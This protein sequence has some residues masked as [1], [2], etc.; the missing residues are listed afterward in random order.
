MEKY[1]KL[2]ILVAS[3]FF[4]K[5]AFGQNKKVQEW[6]GLKVDSSCNLRWSISLDGRFVEINDRTIMADEIK[7]SPSMIGGWNK[8]FYSLSGDIP[9]Y[10][11][12]GNSLLDATF[13]V[14]RNQTKNG[15]PIILSIVNTDEVNM[16]R[17]T[18]RRFEFKF[19]SEKEVDD[20]IAK[21]DSAYIAERKMVEGISNKISETDKNDFEKIKMAYDWVLRTFS[22][23]GDRMGRYSDDKYIV[24]GLDVF[25]E[26]IYKVPFMNNGTGGDYAHSMIL[27]ELFD[28][29]GIE[30]VV[31][32]YAV[33]GS[34]DYWNMAKL[35]GKW[36][37]LDA[38]R[39]VKESRHYK[40]FLV[41]E[42]VMWFG[43]VCEETL[44][45]IRSQMGILGGEY[46]VNIPESP[47]SY[48]L[49]GVTKQMKDEQD[50]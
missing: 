19:A 22:L 2:A 44:A 49:S 27:K 21:I 26:G 45:S 47:T 10:L 7:I 13:R 50:K 4:V 40:C 25:K 12:E 38:T 20:F 30:S 18:I 9:T 36:Y 43:E 14:R 42:K 28:N 8:I 6:E 15:E 1:L 3:L 41:S 39:E 29:I 37:N 34:I 11:L 46:G 48:N 23:G 24:G 33:D 5:D 16:T 31:V 17:G 35:N 32:Y